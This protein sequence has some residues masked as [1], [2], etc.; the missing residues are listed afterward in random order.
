MIPM[1]TTN[2]LYFAVIAPITEMLPPAKSAS[3][4]PTKGYFARQTWMYDSIAAKRQ[5][6]FPDMIPRG[7]DRAMAGLPEC[8]SDEDG[9]ANSGMG[10]IVH[11]HKNDH[12]RIV[13]H[14]VGRYNVQSH[15]FRKLIAW[16]T[17]KPL[18][19]GARA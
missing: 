8:E 14:T 1:N 5:Q 16:L 7:T 19:R 3:Y 9:V 11:Y 2:T 13:K 4:F 10:E 6:N 17:G 15:P 18:P 12:G